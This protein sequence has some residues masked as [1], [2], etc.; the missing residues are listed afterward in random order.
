MEVASTRPAS[1]SKSTSVTSPRPPAAAARPSSVVQTEWYAP[2]VSRSSR[3]PTAGDFL[4]LRVEEGDGPGFGR[5]ENR[6]EDVVEVHRSLPVRPASPP[7][8]RRAFFASSLSGADWTV[9]S[10]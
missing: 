4:P 1:K 5:A 7:R 6:A 8:K 3:S 10:M 2:N 9:R